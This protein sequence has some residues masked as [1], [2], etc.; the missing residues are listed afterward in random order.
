MKKTQRHERR[1][2]KAREDAIEV[3]MTYKQEIEAQKTRMNA[4]YQI[5]IR[6]DFVSICQA[7]KIR[8]HC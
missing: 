1:L 8:G 3:M 4:G 2:A 5:R 6:V 7:R